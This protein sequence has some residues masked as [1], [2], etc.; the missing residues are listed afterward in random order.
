M[1]PNVSK[2][3]P[4][5]NWG[6]LTANCTL[7]SETSCPT[8][9]P[10]T[11]D[12]ASAAGIRRPRRPMTTTSSTS[13]STREPVS[14]TSAAGPQMQEGNFVNTSGSSGSSM[15]DSAAWER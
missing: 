12:Q 3:L 14:R 2:D 9:R 11:C 8:V 6:G 5:E 10:A 15:F 1:G 7:R 4:I 13:Q